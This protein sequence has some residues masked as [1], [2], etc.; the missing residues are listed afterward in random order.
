M[1]SPL[2]KLPEYV[3]N[4]RLRNALKMEIANWKQDASGLQD[5][6]DILE[7]SI[8]L[9]SQSTTVSG[10][11]FSKHCALFVES[12]ISNVGGLTVNERLYWFGLFD[13]WDSSTKGGQNRIRLKIEAPE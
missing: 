2:D 11:D 13:V 10:L 4:R 6:T 12:A 5:L 3:A 9:V 8:G 1:K 7:K